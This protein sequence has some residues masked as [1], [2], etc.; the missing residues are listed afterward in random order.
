MLT[1][2]VNLS[3]DMMELQ[4]SPAGTI[5]LQYRETT[6]ESK[7]QFYYFYFSTITYWLDWLIYFC[8]CLISL[9]AEPLKNF[10][11]VT[12]LELV[13]AGQTVNEKQGAAHC[14]EVVRGSPPG[15][16]S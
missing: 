14:Q 5:Y 8:E 7:Q 6:I 13:T 12:Q 3:G 15:Y 16:T 4:L 9:A 2:C 10:T 11:V 1:E